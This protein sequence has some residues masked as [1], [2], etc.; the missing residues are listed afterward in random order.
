MTQCH[1]TNCN[2]SDTTKFFITKYNMFKYFDS[3]NNSKNI[4]IK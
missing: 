1:N 4:L 3:F 2:T